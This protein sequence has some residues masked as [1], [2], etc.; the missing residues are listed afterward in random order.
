M[1][2]RV[3]GRDLVAG[4]VRV[5]GIAR[6]PDPH[7]QPAVAVDDVVAAV[8]GD[9]VGPAA[10][11]Q[12]VALFPELVTGRDRDQVGQARDAVDAVLVQPVVEE[13]DF[14]LAGDGGRH[15][16]VTDQRVIVVPAGQGLDRVEPVAQHVGLIG[17]EDLDPHVGVGVLGHALED[18]PVETVHPLVAHHAGALHHDVVAGF[19]V[20]VVFVRSRE[21]DVVTDDQAVEEQFGVVTCGRV[22][23][24]ARL[25]PVVAFVAQQE[26]RAVAAQD[27]VVAFAAEDFGRVDT[28]EDGVLAASAH[29]DV[30][31][32]GGGDDVVTF[33]AFQEVAFVTGIDDDV[34]AAAAVHEVHAEARLDVVVAVVA[35]DAVVAVAGDDRVVAAGAA[36]DDVF[37]TGEADVVRLDLRRRRIVT[38]HL[39]H[40]EGLED[41][42]V[43]DR[44]GDQLV[45]LVH[46]E[47]E[48]VE[49][50]G[51]D[52]DVVADDVVRGAAD[53]VRTRVGQAGVGQQH[54]REGV[55]FQF[56]E[57]VLTLRPRQVVEPVAVLQRLHLRLE[58]GGEGRSQHPAEGHDALGQA[59][60]PEVDAVQAAGFGGPAV[61]AQQEVQPLRVGDRAAAEDQVEGRV[62][63]LDQGRRHLDALMGAVGRDQVDDRHRRLEVRC[64]LDPVAVGLQPGR[65][66]LLVKFGTRIV[67]GRHAGVAAPGDVDRREVE[68]QAQQVAAQRGHDEF[69]DLAAPLGRHPQ[70]H[71]GRRLV[72][73]HRAV[74]V[75]GHRVQ[76][77]GDQAHVV[78]GHAAGAVDHDPRHAVGQHG[79]A[80][81]VHHV[82]EFGED[83]RVD[84]GH[85]VEDEGVD[86]R[87]DLAAELLEHEVL[88]LHLG[89]EAGRLEQPLAVPVQRGRV[90]RDLGDVGQQEFVDQVDVAG[91]EQRRLVGLDLT[92]VLGVEDVVDGRQADVLVPASVAGDEVTIQQF[93]VVGAGLDRDLCAVDHAVSVGVA[94]DDTVRI[95][96]FQR[97]GLAVE[98][99]RRMGDIVKER[100]SDPHRTG[101]EGVHGERQ[102]ALH[103]VVVG[104]VRNSV[105]TQPD[106]DLRQAVVTPHEFAVRVGPQQRDVQHV[107]IRQL[108]AEEGRGI[109]LD[110]A[111]GR[112][113]AVRAVQQLAGRD[114]PA[115]RVEGVFAQED[116]VR[117]MRRV[118]LVLIDE[119]RRRVAAFVRGVVRGAHDAVGAGAGQRGGAC[120]GHEAQAR[121]QIVGRAGDAVGA[122][123]QRVVGLERHEDGAVVALGDEVEAVIEELAEEG[124][125][126]VE[127]GGDAVIGRDVRDRRH[128][129]VVD[130]D[131]VGRGRRQRDVV[132]E[133]LRTAGL[134]DLDPQ[135]MARDPGGHGARVQRHFGPLAVGR[136]GQGG[137]AED[138]LLAARTHGNQAG[139]AAGPVLIRPVA[140]AQPQ[141][142]VRVGGQR[143]AVLRQRRASG[144]PGD[145]RPG[146]SR[147][148]RQG[149][150]GREQAAGAGQHPPRRCGQGVVPIRI[151]QD[152]RRAI[153]QRL[154]LEA[155][156]GHRL[157]EHHAFAR[158][159]GD[160]VLAIAGVEGGQRTVVREPGVDGGRVGDALIVDEVRDDA[161]IRIG[162]VAGMAAVRGRPDPDD[163]VVVVGD[164]RTA[165]RPERHDVAVVLVDEVGVQHAR[166]RLVRGTPGFAAGHEVVVGAVDRAQPVGHEGVGDGRQRA[167]R[168]GVDDVAERID[169]DFGQRRSGGMRLADLDLPQ[170]E[171]QVCD[172]ELNGHDDIPLVS[173]L[174]FATGNPE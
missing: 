95:R 171:F 35:P 100:M 141:A 53:A 3:D 56:V 174:A 48:V 127:G 59:T 125:P 137:R 104:G 65:I 101:G 105:G 164:G 128:V 154:R 131:H 52:A 54:L 103:D 76:E 6:D 158:T 87:M 66:G 20:E 116:L 132:D 58:H 161:R 13:R 144:Q 10:A 72:R 79:M 49:T 143:H 43:A 162:D 9:Q 97:V 88:V 39:A 67:E 146:M 38:H 25:H 89:G 69:V 2:Q 19:R 86:V 70:D 33:L 163:A 102:V 15:P 156:V 133:D 18:G 4:Q 172:V 29:Q 155:A 148:G 31:A 167:W 166:H 80:E 136:L 99:V 165:R 160:R 151:R 45:G 135:R 14:V 124:H 145:V 30:G 82:G 5:G 47:H 152:V 98:R 147:G 106:D 37:A 12:D 55:L 44:I 71:G 111:P 120:D 114:R 108:D 122:Q 96:G 34:V 64:Q 24:A 107:A 8:A 27:E 123:N 1:L 46:L 84:V 81:A 74:V 23:A 94:V 130:L 93:V 109:G 85:R 159:N 118:G 126:G 173:R 112:Q 139:D 22:E 119:G 83:G 32:V 150:D 134:L 62:A 91:P 17:R 138:R 142:I 110:L 73:G 42:V 36:D 78:G 115:R 16:V 63:L 7:V 90:R 50:E 169:P 60:D 121:G 117:G 28:E 41:R 40:A 113:A 77:R 168:A 61:A 68:R 153:G 149:I 140:D 51:V 170:D 11:Q 26:V 57:Q 157:I 129:D 92:V 21:H 75:E